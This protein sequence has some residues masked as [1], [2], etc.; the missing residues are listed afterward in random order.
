MA[1][2][3]RATLGS[4]APTPDAGHEAGDRVLQAAID[5]VARRLRAQRAFNTAATLGL[6]GLGIA[7]LAL[8]LQK[9]GHAADARPYVVLAN[10]LPWLGLLLGASRKVSSLR[11]ARLL[12]RSLGTPDLLASASSFAELSMSERT[13]FMQ[14][15]IDHARH[16]V[17]HVDPAGALPLRAPRALRPAAGLALGLALLAL[18]HVPPPAPLVARFV[19]KLPVLENEDLEAFRQEIARSLAAQQSDPSVRDAARELNALLEALHDRKLDRAQALEQLHSVE[20]RLGSAELEQEDDALREALRALGQTLGRDTNVRA[21]AEAMR[22]A[23][24]ESARAALER[25]AQTLRE[26]APQANARHELQRALE[27]AGHKAGADADERL[28]QARADLERLLKRRDPKREPSEQTERLLRKKQ[29]E[30]E[31]LERERAQRERGQRQLDGLQR[32]LSSAAQSM[33]A[34]QV[35]QASQ[36]LQQGAEQLQKAQSTEASSEQRRQLRE[37][38][39]QFREL[40]RKQQ[41]E[42][43]ARSDQSLQGK[44]QH[45]SLRD[46]SRAAGGEPAKP[47]TPGGRPGAGLSLPGHGD[48]SNAAPLSLPGQAQQA[49]PRV[50]RGE[51]VGEAPGRDGRPEADGDPSRLASTRVDARVDGEQR[52]GPTRSEVILE[53]GQHGFASRSYQRVH[54]EYERHAEAVLERDQ[55]PGGYRFYVRRYFQ[56]IRPREAR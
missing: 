42:Q 45:L 23:D 12:D 16:R 50:Q 34:G 39:Q 56:L 2:M 20:R 25:L 21:V 15:C 38:V 9:T 31:Q 44:G 26:H 32:E 47:E 17:E 8:C 41:R 14:A 3:E 10:V 28:T 40:I 48:E 51:P 4:A 27:R 11:V 19:P 22:E 54:G 1:S 18:L 55:I 53:A 46:F 52:E 7:A 6:A 5:A 37:R 49:G 29:R 36:H 43:V 24:A 30:L 33:K 35:R 13:P